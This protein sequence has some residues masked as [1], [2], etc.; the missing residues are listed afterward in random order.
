MR[1]QGSEDVVIYSRVSSLGQKNDGHRL[2]GQEARCRNFA[3]SKGWNVV[4]AFP[5]TISGGIDFMKRPGMKALLAFLDAQPDKSFIVLFDDP[6][7]FARSTKY[8]LKLREAL[9]ARGA[10]IACLN[11]KFEEDSPEGEFI[12]TIMAAQGALERK[13][14][15]RQVAQKMKAKPIR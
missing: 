8:H 9:R 15:G 11:F 5:D 6:K 3:A 14:N 2:S 12:E 13:Q 7:R 1:S 4:A 10:R